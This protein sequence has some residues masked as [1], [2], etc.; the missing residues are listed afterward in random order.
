MRFSVALLGSR[1]RSFLGDKRQ[2][3]TAKN[4]ED[5]RVCAGIDLGTSNS[6]LAILVN[7]VPEVVPNKEGERLTPS[8]VAYRQEVDGSVNMLVGRP[9]RQQAHMNPEN[10]FSSVKRFIGRQASEL[11]DAEL[12]RAPYRV[13]KVGSSL[14]VYCPLLDKLFAPEEIS[15]QVMRKLSRDASERLGGK[16]IKD[17]VITVPAYFGDSQRLA[18]KDAGKIAGLNVLRILNEPTGASLFWGL[19]K[20]ETGVALVFDLGGFI[21][22]GPQ[23]PRSALISA[24]FWA[25]CAKL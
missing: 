8:V 9:A 25:I 6:V 3:M 10:T 16:S 21:R 12:K 13:D 17:V 20:R 24:L 14:R 18:T 1:F 2:N 19:G 15:A 5:A 11:D 7:G 23:W 4:N 22:R